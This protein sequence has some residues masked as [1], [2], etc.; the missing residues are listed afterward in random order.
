VPRIAFH[1]PKFLKAGATFI[2]YGGTGARGGFSFIPDFTQYALFSLWDDRSLLEKFYKN[3][4]EI[5]ECKR[6]ALSW[7]NFILQPYLSHGTWDG[8]RFL[9]EDSPKLSYLGGKVAVL[10][11]ASIRWQKLIRFWGHV[12]TAGREA[13]LNRDRV[14]S[15]GFGELPW[16]RQATFSVWENETSM[17]S[18]AYKS[19]HHAQVVKRTRVEKWYSEEMFTRFNVLEIESGGELQVK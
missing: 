13:L 7:H 18:F 15:L 10:T 6:D 2:R 12:P 3:S 4:P 17:K 11:R 19:D 16:V 5:A 1:P 8:E 14:F 9:K